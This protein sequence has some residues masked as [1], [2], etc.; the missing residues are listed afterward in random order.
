MAVVGVAGRGLII[1]RLDNTPTEV[2]RMESPLK[3][4]HRCVSI[5]RDK[6]NQPTGKGK[7]NQLIRYNN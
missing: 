7:G 6:Q 2:K 4:Q 3:Y 1:Y 5:F